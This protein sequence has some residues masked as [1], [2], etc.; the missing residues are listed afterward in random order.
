GL[1]V[2]VHLAADDQRGV[3]AGAAH[4]Q[5][6]DVG[7]ADQLADVGGADGAAG[8]TRVDQVHRLPDGRR[9]GV[10]AAARAGHQ[11]APLETGGPQLAVQLLQVALDQRLDVGVDDGGAGAL[12]LPVLA[13]QLM[14]EGHGNAGTDLLQHLAHG[15]LVGG[16]HV[17]VQ[18]ADGHRFD[19]FLL[20][21]LR[22]LPGRL[23]VERLEH[24]ALEVHPL[25][26]LEAQVAGHQRLRLAV[27]EVVH[28]IPGRAPEDEHVAEP[29]GGD[30]GHPGARPRQQR[31]ETQRGAVDEVADGLK[32]GPD[33][34]E[35]GQHALG[36]ILR[37]GFGLFQADLAFLLVQQDH[38]REGAADVYGDAHRTGMPPAVNMMEDLYASAFR[39]R[40]GASF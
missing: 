21:A 23:V 36:G 30:D 32:V 8:G 34:V 31:V 24:L 15:D 40:G 25:G 17:A 39:P 2:Q 4:V 20:D 37:R 12:V 35:A 28:D 6:D 5:G 19:G 13:A 14:R 27:L 33:L 10:G 9:Q 18:E 7:L 26:N 38:V 29:F 3:Q 1:G 16:V 22:H 11:E